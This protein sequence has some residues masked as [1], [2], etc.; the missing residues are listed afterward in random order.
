[1]TYSALYCL[2]C[3]VSS[4]QPAC[5]QPALCS[6]YCTAHITQPALCSLHCAV[7]IVQPAL[8][9]LYCPACIVSICVHSLSP[10]IPATHCHNMLSATLTITVTHHHCL[11]HNRKGY[12]SISVCSIA[13]WITGLISNYHNCNCSL[14]NSYLKKLALNSNWK[15]YLADSWCVSEPGRRVWNR[16]KQ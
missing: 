1:M 15:Q 11:V 16:F 2:H 4:L 9:S 7:C 14:V 3:S 13:F 12:N 10:C 8:Y 6:L 5:V